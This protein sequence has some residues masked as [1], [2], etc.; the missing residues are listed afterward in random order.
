MNQNNNKPN[1]KNFF[2]KLL[3]ITISIII[4]INISYNLIFADKMENKN[5]VL[6]LN[7]KENIENIKEKIRLE[8]KKGLNK[9]KVLS[10]EDKVLL[11][12]FYKKLKKEFETVK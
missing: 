1:L 8:I 9:D 10:D 2:I 11:Y 5:K 7:E 12:E 6:S 3:A 4:I